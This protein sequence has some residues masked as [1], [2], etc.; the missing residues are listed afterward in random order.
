MARVEGKVAI[1]TGGGSGIGAATAQRLAQEGAR[2]VVTDID[3]ASAARTADAIATSGAEA[4]ALGHD[5]ALEADWIR[6]VAATVARFGA[7]TILINNAGVY[8]VGRLSELA[9]DQWDWLMA[10]N[11]RGVALGIKHV[12]RPMAEAGGG[13][14][15]NLSSVAGI[16]GAS[17][18]ALY[19]ASKGAVRA[20][21]KSA[22]IE[23]GP[24]KVRV[25]SV[26]P[27][28]IE[29]PMADYGARELGLTKEK[30]TR[31][32]PLGR[33]GTALEVANAILFLASDEASFIT[34]AE[35]LVDGGVTAQ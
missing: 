19:S 27:A 26:H 16:I 24:T 9:V 8:R 6:V 17:Q 21:T 11:V 15:V 1:V 30:L 32:Y 14:V 12:A 20:L 35:L 13:A 23:L 10:I 18:H 33:L 25:N 29:T 22:A 3:E 34:G 31:G 7:P 28:I 4:L 2:V 5:V